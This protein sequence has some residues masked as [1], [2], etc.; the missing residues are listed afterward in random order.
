MKLHKLVQLYTRL[1]TLDT[2]PARSEIDTLVHQLTVFK[3]GANDEY[4]FQL[5][6]LIGVLDDIKQ[7]I[8]QAE[9]EVTYVRSLVTEDISSASAKFFAD[10]YQEELIC[11]DPDRVRE[12]R[13]L[14]IPNGVLDYVT[15]SID[16]YTDWRYPGLEIGCRDG[17]MTRYLVALDPL[18]IVDEHQ[19]FLDSTLSKQTPEY[20]AKLRPYLLR[21]HNLSMLPKNQLGFVFSWNYFNYITL[22]TTKHYLAQVFDLLRPGGTFMFSYN[23]AELP[24][25]ASYADS[26][27]MSYMPKHLL[28]AAST[29]AGFEVTSSTDFEPAV[30]WIELRKPG[31]LTSIKAHPVLGEIKFAS[32]L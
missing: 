24:D 18:Y 31:T 1:G 11:R 22:E 9:E 12:I 16:L 28:V 17:E 7:E 10:N 5:D 19:I 25:A 2:S 15:N 13:Q 32:P 4:L 23:N 29:A 20:R 21:K 14:Y 3:D 30:S 6:K 27:Y 26:Y 8:K